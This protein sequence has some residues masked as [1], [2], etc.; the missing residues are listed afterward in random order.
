MKLPDYWTVPEMDHAM[1]RMLDEQKEAALKAG[2]NP[3]EVDRMIKEASQKAIDN[4]Q[5]VDTAREEFLAQMA[6]ADA[7]KFGSIARDTF[8][9]YQNLVDEYRIEVDL[10]GDAA[11]QTNTADAWTHKWTKGDELSDKFTMDLAAMY[12]EAA[13]FL[14]DPE[15]LARMDEETWEQVIA[16]LDA[17]DLAEMKMWAAQGT[18]LGR[19][20]VGGAQATETYYNAMQGGRGLRDESFKG[21]YRAFQLNPSQNA[22][23][24]ILHSTERAHQIGAWNARRLATLREELGKGGAIHG[25]DLKQYWKIRNRYWDEYTEMVVGQNEALEQVI[26]QEGSGNL[27]WNR[28]T[29]GIRAPETTPQQVLA[30]RLASQPEP[31]ALE[32]LFLAMHRKM[33]KARTIA[34]TAAAR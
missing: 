17:Y 8:H 31:F 30:H 28:A 33:R 3:E 27:T 2:R 9:K 34:R 19:A 7:Q 26:L 32:A 14:Q 10:L 20:G 6:R 15:Y 21:L 11:V 1:A 25:E 13:T 22:F 23:D 29:G 4:R 18:E 12:D 5:T 24:L 16:R